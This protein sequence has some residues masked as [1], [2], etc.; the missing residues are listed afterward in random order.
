MNYNKA[1]LC[2]DCSKPVDKRNHETDYREFGPIDRKSIQL[3]AHLTDI[4]Y[5]TEARMELAGAIGANQLV[6]AYRNIQREQDKLGHLPQ[7]LSNKRRQ[8]DRTLERMVLRFKNG[9]EAMR[10][11]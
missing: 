10:A 2:K 1:E 9:R 7:R 8:L 11:L 6:N 5:H 3:V 4:N